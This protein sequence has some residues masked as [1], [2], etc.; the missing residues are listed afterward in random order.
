MRLHSRVAA[1]VSRE[2]LTRFQERNFHV[3]NSAI[4]SFQEI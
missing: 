4:K 2:P 3:A 1:R